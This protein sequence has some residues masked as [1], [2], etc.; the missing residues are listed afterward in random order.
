[1]GAG[2]SHSAHTGRPISFC[3][4]LGHRIQLPGMSPSSFYGV[5]GH[6]I[7]QIWDIPSNYQRVLG[8]PIQLLWDV[9]SACCVMVP[10]SFH[11]L[12]GHPTWRAGIGR[13]DVPVAAMGTSQPVSIYLTRPPDGRYLCFYHLK[14]T[15]YFLIMHSITWGRP[16]YVIVILK[17]RPLMPCAHYYHLL[18]SSRWDVLGRL[19]QNLPSSRVF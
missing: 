12:T 3:C 8:C 5:L 11:W 18:C 17:G 14:Y 13:W 16:L 15:I 10:A 7:Q 19:Y 2:T 9:P 1:L 6:P 4:V